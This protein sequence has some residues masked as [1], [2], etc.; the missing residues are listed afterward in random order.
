M[1]NKQESKLLPAEEALIPKV[2]PEKNNSVAVSNSKGKDY[3]E[4]WKPF[5]ALKIMNVN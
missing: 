5:V 2:V 1:E 4:V 3:N